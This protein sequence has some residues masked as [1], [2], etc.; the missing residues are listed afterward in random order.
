MYLSDDRTQRQRERA[1]ERHMDRTQRQRERA[2]ERHMERG[3]GAAGQ[4][5]PG[6][7]VP[8]IRREEG[9]GR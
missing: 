4:V 9:G 6:A 8:E 1:M 3:R 2:M 7:A 5:S